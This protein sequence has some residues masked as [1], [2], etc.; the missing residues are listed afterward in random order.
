VE[1]GIR[2][3]QSGAL[4]L[5]SANLRCEAGDRAAVNM[6]RCCVVVEVAFYPEKDKPVD[7]LLDD[8]SLQPVNADYSARPTSPQV[9]AAELEAPSNRQVTTTETV[10]VGCESGTYIDPV[11]GRPAIASPA[12]AQGKFAAIVA[13]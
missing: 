5:E 9:V 3:T 8:F 11:T 12:T 1:R 4:S 6:N 2:F 7:V 10:G 13:F